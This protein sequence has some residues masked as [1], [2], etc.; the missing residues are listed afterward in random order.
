MSKKLTPIVLASASPRRKQLLQFFSYPFEEMPHTFDERKVPWKGAPRDY[1][2]E[3]AEK[4]AMDVLKH[5]HDRI[6]ISADTIVTKDG[7]LFNKPRN[8][9]EAEEMLQE[10]S[11]TWHTVLTA[12]AVAVNGKVSAQAEETRV[13]LSPLDKRHI[14]LYLK[15]DEWKDKAAG[16]A[17]QGVGSLIVQRIEGCYYNVMGL[18]ISLLNKMLLEAGIDLWDYLQ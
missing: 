18:P 16:Y 5:C 9:Q 6:V 17:I 13:L 1:V 3:L 12:I 4:K 2:I 10:L 14:D 8:R 7:K 15:L 11:G